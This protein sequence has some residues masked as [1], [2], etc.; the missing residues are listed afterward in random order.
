V[1]RVTVADA[2][3]PFTETFVYRTDGSPLEMLYQ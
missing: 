3:D 2:A 1:G